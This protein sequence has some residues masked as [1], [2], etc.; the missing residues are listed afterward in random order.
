MPDPEHALLTPTPC[1]EGLEKAWV[2]RF[3]HGSHSVCRKPCGWPNLGRDRNADCYRVG[4]PAFVV[5]TL[6]LG[7]VVLAAN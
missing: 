6:I 3:F 2:E 1:P 4:D 7:I 5:L